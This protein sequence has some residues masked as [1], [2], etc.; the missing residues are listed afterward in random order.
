[1]SLPTPAWSTAKKLPMVTF[2]PDFRVTIKSCPRWVTVATLS[3]DTGICT[4]PGP[5][6]LMLPQAL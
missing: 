5:L 6:R 2:S 1:M 3:G 4:T